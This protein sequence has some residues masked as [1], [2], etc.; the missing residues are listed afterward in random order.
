M[1]KAVIYIKERG[2]NKVLDIAMIGECDKIDS[3]THTIISNGFAIKIEIPESLED[4]EIHEL[5]CVLVSEQ[6]SV[7]EVPDSWS[8]GTNT[9]YD[10]NDIPTI[11]DEDEKPMLDDSYVKT[12]GVAAIAY[13]AKHYEI[14]LKQ[15]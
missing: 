5:K 8:D 6:V 3:W 2:H 4:K 14:K 11:L 10:I 15:D 12:A 9:V 7:D 1:K 13:V